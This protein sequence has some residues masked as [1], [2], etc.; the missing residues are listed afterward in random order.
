MKNI[1]YHDNTTG[2]QY[3]EDHMLTNNWNP[4]LDYGNEYVS[5]YF[6]VETKGY[7]YPDFCFSDA[8]RKAFDKDI[9]SVFGNLGWS[10]KEKAYRGTCATYDNGASHLY[11]HPQNFSGVILKNDVK[12][13]AEALSSATA[14]S[15]RWVDLYETVYDMD[16]DT[17]YA[18]LNE[19]RLLKLRKQ[20]VHPATSFWG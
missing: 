11:L 8:D 7:G 9:E 13:V 2:V 18:I 14:F 17:Y 5:V 15:L 4:D 19:Q 10:C 6:R 16:D 3:G 12:K 20:L 1:K